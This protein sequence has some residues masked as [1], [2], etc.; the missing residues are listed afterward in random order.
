MDHERKEHFMLRNPVRS[1]GESRSLSWP[2]W[3]QSITHITSDLGIKLARGPSFDDPEMF[4]RHCSKW[5]MIEKNTL[6]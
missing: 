2:S 5:I 1:K 4:N 6:G 3:A